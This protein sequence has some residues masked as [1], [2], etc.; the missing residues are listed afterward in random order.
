MKNLLN[1][2]TPI[3]S[4][5]SLLYYNEFDVTAWLNRHSPTLRSKSTPG[6]KPRTRRRTYIDICCAF[7]IETSRVAVDSKGSPNTIMYIWQ[8]QFGLDCTIYGRYW[9][10]FLTVVRLINAWAEQ[11]NEETEL[12]WRVVCY[13]HNLSH[14]FQYLAGIWNFDANDVFVVR[15]RRILRAD[16]GALELRCSMLHSNMSLAKYTDQMGAPH[17]KAVG[18][19]DYNVV[20]YPWTELTDAEMHYCVNDV[21]GLVEAI[22]IEMQRDKDDLYTIPLTSTGY[23]RRDAKRAMSEYGMRY[24]RPLL[25]DYECYKALREAFRGGDTH[26][27]RYY[28][29]ITLENVKSVDMSSAYPAVQC[30]CRFPVTPLRR[31]EPSVANLKRELRRKHAVLVRIAITGLEQINKAWGMPYLPRAKCR[32]CINYVND[33]G[34]LLSAEYLETTVNDIDLKIIC[35]EYKFA[36]LKVLDLW[37]AKYGELPRKLTDVVKEYFGK[38]TALKGVAGEEYIYNKSKNKLN[39]VYG[40]SAQ[41]PCPEDWTYCAGEYVHDTDNAEARYEDNKKHIFLPYQ[42]G[43]WT[44]AHT[45]RR[46]KIAQYAAGDGCVYCDTDSVKYIGDCPLDAYNSNVK[47]EAKFRGAM[48]RDPQGVPHY[49]GVFE[50]EKTY[51]LFKTWGAKKY[52]TAYEK[53]GPLTTTIAGVSKKD[54]GEELMEAGGLDAFRPDFTFR[55]AAGKLIVYNDAPELSPI[56]GPS[57]EVVEITRNLCICDN[58][59]TVGITAEYA[60]LL[61]IRLEASV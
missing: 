28:T 59:Y 54:G 61:G 34:R 4:S 8:M 41:D 42:W 18:E 10:E 51:A 3:S 11:K 9:H 32:S 40:M 31:M 19:L 17:A 52:V 22:C 47:A 50:Q 12:D 35:K 27:N 33:N 58:T 37:S 38:K 57:G 44:T 14:E 49:M 24:I 56:I 39:S 5:E 16:M 15:S 23:V 2:Q 13:V 26:A 29:G 60:A 20:R 45:R 1:S 30:E 7:D 43:V 48:A 25:P 6:R 55:R 53:D 21:R 36:G 46:L